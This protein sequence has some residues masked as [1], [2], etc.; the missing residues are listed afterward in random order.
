MSKTAFITGASGGIGSA[1]AA[2]LMLTLRELTRALLGEPCAYDGATVAGT[3]AAVDNRL[4][5]E[6]PVRDMA[7]LAGVRGRAG[8][9]SQPLPRSTRTIRS[10]HR[11]T[12]PRWPSAIFVMDH[13]TTGHSSPKRALH[14]GTSTS[15]TSTSASPPF[16]PPPTTARLQPT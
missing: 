7:V 9:S 16:R 14:G 12:P 10:R 1:I 13:H 8:G 2:K 4:V 3:A 5:A 15:R 11:P 6:F